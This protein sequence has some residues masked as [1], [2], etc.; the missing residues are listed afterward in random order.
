MLLAV[1]AAGGQVSCGRATDT[2]AAGDCV[3]AR[4]TSPPR[5]HPRG[6]RT[7][8][9]GAA[10]SAR[11]LPHSA[12]P[13]AAAPSL[14][15]PPTPVHGR[16]ALTAANTLQTI[17]VP[18]DTLIDVRLEP[19]SGLV[20]TL[21]ESSDPQALPR[22]SA[23]GAC[24]TVKTATFRAVRGGEIIATRPHADSE[25]RLLVTVRVAG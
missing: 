14:P 6:P 2:G 25:A 12:P 24:D 5:S 11:V 23:S 13:P 21:P 22:V 9:A 7:G 19:V 3:Q 20:W 16:L 18:A 17:V 15:P 8:P 4:T 1:L 10:G